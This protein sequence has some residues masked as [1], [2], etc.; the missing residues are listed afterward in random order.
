MAG[1]R[2][3]RPLRASSPRRDADAWPPPA[4]TRWLGTCRAP[5]GWDE[6]PAT[7][8]GLCLEMAATAAHIR[9]T[10]S[11]GVAAAFRSA[12]RAHQATAPEE[13]GSRRFQNRLYPLR[14][15]RTRVDQTR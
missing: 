12:V 7:A 11:A 10:Q 15:L 6:M 3:P 14:I 5:A 13:P 9:I 2:A 8:A 1:T 4:P